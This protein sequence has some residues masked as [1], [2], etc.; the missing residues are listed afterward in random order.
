MRFPNYHERIKSYL[1]EQFNLPEEQ[2]ASMLPEFIRTLSSHM[3]GLEESF[4]KQNYASLAKAGHTIKGAF[5]N[6]G[7]PE[8]AEVALQIEEEARIANGSEDISDLV[9]NLRQIVND[10]INE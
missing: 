2:V 8:G 9:S 5:L 6:L 4:Q 7:L 10:I 3:E 1:D